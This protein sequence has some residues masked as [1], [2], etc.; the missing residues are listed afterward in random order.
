MK[1]GII[2]T[3]SLIVIISFL[4]Q[5][6]VW[7]QGTDKVILRHSVENSYLNPASQLPGLINSATILALITAAEVI[8]RSLDTEDPSQIIREL[9]DS[10]VP[11]QT[12]A[13]TAVLERI[14]GIYFETG[15]IY[16]IFSLRGK[17]KTYRLSNRTEDQHYEIVEVFFENLD[18]LD[19]RSLQVVRKRSGAETR[20]QGLVSAELPR[21]D[22]NAFQLLQ[23]AGSGSLYREGTAEE[24]ERDDDPDDRI[25]AVEARQKLAVIL[26]KTQNDQQLEQVTN[27]AYDDAADRV[28]S[29]V[30]NSRVHL[31]RGARAVEAF[32][33]GAQRSAFVNLTRDNYLRFYKYLSSRGLENEARLVLQTYLEDQ[34]RHQ[35]KTLLPPS[36]LDFIAATRFRELLGDNAETVRDYLLAFNLLDVGSQ[37]CRLCGDF[38][39]KYEL[40]RKI[41]AGSEAVIYE[42]IEIADGTRRAIK[43]RTPQVDLTAT[44]AGN[45]RIQ[46]LGRKRFLREATVLRRL[47]R[48]DQLRIAHYHGHGLG[49]KVTGSLRQAL[50][51]NLTEKLQK[52]MP[53]L[54]AVSG[55]GPDYMV[56]DYLEGS[57][58]GEVIRSEGK[59]TPRRAAVIFGQVA[60]ILQVLHEEGIV[61]RDL[62]PENLMVVGEEVR[63]I[64]FSAAMPREK[65]AG[66]KSG[67]IWGTPEYLAPE[68]I[69][70]RTEVAEEYRERRDLFA[71][72]VSL[73]E[74]LFNEHPFSEAV[75]QEWQ[76]ANPNVPAI[77]LSICHA[78]PD[79]GLLCSPT[80]PKPLQAVMLTCLEKDP[81]RRLSAQQVRNLLAD[82]LSSYEIDAAAIVADPGL[83]VASKKQV[84]EEKSLAEK[85][86][87]RRSIAR[88]IKKFDSMRVMRLMKYAFLILLACLSG[89]VSVLLFKNLEIVGALVVVILITLIVLGLAIGIIKPNRI[90]DDWPETFPLFRT[91]ISFLKSSEV[92][93]TA[94]DDLFWTL[95]LLG[96][97][98]FRGEDIHSL[99]EDK[100]IAIPQV[101][102]PELDNRGIS[103]E[104]DLKGCVQRALDQI[105]DE[106]TRL[107]AR[108]PKQLWIAFLTDPL[109][110]LDAPL[111]VD[112]VGVRSS[113]LNLFS[114]FSNIGLREEALKVLQLYLER[115]ILEILGETDSFALAQRDARRFL[116]LMSNDGADP[117]RAVLVRDYLLAFGFISPESLLCRSC[118]KFQG[119][120]NLK[121]VI[122][123]GG[124]AVVYEAEKELQDGTKET[125]I[126]K[127]RRP[128]VVFREGDATFEEDD[129]SW[130]LFAREINFM[131]D[132]KDIV[133]I[134]RCKNY[135]VG[136]PETGV[137]W[138]EMDYVPGI[139]LT[140]YIN[141]YSCG[142]PEAYKIIS[143]VANI[144]AKLHQRG[145]A[146]RDLKPDNI[147]VSL[148]PDN[149]IARITLLDFGLAVDVAEI[150]KEYAMIDDVFG[151]TQYMSP[152]RLRRKE[153]IEVQI[154][155][156]MFALGVLFYQLLT[157][158]KHPYPGVDMAESEID[159]GHIICNLPPQ[160]N[161][162][163][164]V[165]GEIR[166]LIDNCI[167]ERCSAAYVMEKLRSYVRLG[168]SRAAR[169]R[170]PR[171]MIVSSLPTLLPGAAAEPEPVPIRGAKPLEI[172]L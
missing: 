58:L 54:K 145:L 12:A 153:G 36:D 156:D 133:E 55:P 101:N 71:L 90:I 23:A 125:T 103:A 3:I 60:E 170:E 2:K 157:R 10:W 27:E 13:R 162:V 129:N 39:G 122:G 45:H 64:D 172:S 44:A 139:L 88:Y 106:D 76:K 31:P 4:G 107:F 100:E 131:S 144:I 51:Y 171:A 73:F 104:T 19:K 98:V 92:A 25:T 116:E 14:K 6:L 61:H 168:N 158:G 57:S 7:A 80:I 164:S 8:S 79:M 91:K 114:Y 50:R 82:F 140:E 89:S 150:E 62:K 102:I 53:D 66:E 21:P 108:L 85:V 72:A 20:E 138:F 65:I 75:S 94:T 109:R 70:R 147:L 110:V 84:R 151:S 81:Q 148:N 56:L 38:R 86:H 121:K 143:G 22:V 28:S 118:G 11:A 120:Y 165:P 83:A 40:K 117:H 77:M 163:V 111:A 46:Q 69:M 16:I 35:I 126:I 5:S 63:L 78:S 15:D 34:I 154:G 105:K 32:F 124:F 142:L 112:I 132:N 18:S 127:I 9:R 1:K 99:G 167:K 49:E 128:K 24:I 161:Y 33:R 59:L 160:Y 37:V 47:K 52:A 141:D 169:R 113:Y 42:A 123:R 93:Q 48:H 74:V 115:Q 149:S 135:S 136:E 96:K 30:P 29:E 155:G 26:A 146:H 87:N 119:R 95:G 17:E 166:E 97:K 152:D 43:V 68:A 159:I 134:P 41:G 67:Y 130:Y 137:H